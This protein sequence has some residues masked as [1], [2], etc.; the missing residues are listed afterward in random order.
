MLTLASPELMRPTNS[1]MRLGFVP[2][3]ATMDGAAMIFGTIREYTQM[4]MLRSEGND[5]SRRY[6]TRARLK[7]DAIYASVTV[8]GG[9]VIGVRSRQSKS[10]L[11]VVPACYGG[12]CSSAILR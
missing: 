5:G 3:A 12:S 4:E 8:R 2:A 6:L 10:A 7:P 11:T 9:R 1:S